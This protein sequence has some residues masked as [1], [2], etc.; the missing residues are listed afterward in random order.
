[1]R[2]ADSKGPASSPTERVKAGIAVRITVPRGGLTA[3]CHPLDWWGPSRGAKPTMVG[4]FC[5]SRSAG[6]RKQPPDNGGRG[7]LAG[8]LSCARILPAGSP[9]PKVLPR[10]RPHCCLYASRRYADGCRV[11]QATL[12][13]S[14]GVSSWLCTGGMNESHPS[15]FAKHARPTSRRSGGSGGLPVIRELP[16]ATRASALGL[17]NNDLTDS[18]VS[19]PFPGCSTGLVDSHKN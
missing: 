10:R 15:R 17:P 6:T 19:Y 16:S 5:R 7:V 1:M 9:D 4:K 3:L 14:E 13:I 8:S 12:E 11:A 2:N 18:T